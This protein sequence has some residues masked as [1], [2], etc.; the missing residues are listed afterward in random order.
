VR[1]Y[2]SYTLGNHVENL[3]LQYTNNINGTG[4]ALN[5][6]IVGNSGNN[7]LD[8]GAG[9]DTYTANA[10]GDT[11]IFNLLSSVSSTGGNGVDMWTDFQV[12]TGVA[13]RIDIGALL[14]GYNSS[15]NQIY[16]DQFISV[17]NSSGNTSLYVDRDGEGTQ[18]ND[19]LLLTLSNVNT[20]LNTLLSNDQ[21]ILV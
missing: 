1:S 11:L 7:I 21:L 4:N 17:E 5:N 20:N 2:I 16:I 18:F 9:N 12:G 13:D 10:G 19:T 3:E 8:G 6:T 14:V 15:E